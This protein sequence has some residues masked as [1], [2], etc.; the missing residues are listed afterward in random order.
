MTYMVPVGPP[1]LMEIRMTRLQASFGFVTAAV[2]VGALLVGKPT[3]ASAGD[4]AAA[5]KFSTFAS[6]DD[7]AAELKI[8]NA[9]LKKAVVSEAEY[10]DQVEGRFT[11]DA[12][13]IALIAIAL[14]LHD[15]DSALKPQAKAIAAAARKLAEAKDYAATKQAV[16]DLKAATDG[17]GKGAIELKWGKVSKLPGLMKDQV[18][19][20]NNKLKT[21]L[22][23][24]KK[25]TG[26]VAANAA[27]MALIAE[28]ATLYV[29]DT[30]KPT[31]GKK[32][33]KFSAD[34]RAAAV[35]L[36]AK[37]HNGD[38]AG[39]KAAMENLDQSCHACHDVF[40]PEKNAAINPAKNSEEK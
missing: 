1:Y 20:I 21:A 36:A 15:Q 25:R 37:A 16:E 19:A 9:D 5:P 7:L 27:T 13:T 11:R 24:F 22:R 4:D 31:E 26:E 2:L 38:E 32:W 6:A 39:A 3:S 28:N 33:T 8:L 18:P 14:G 10:K 17:E 35:D 34:M 30:K 12:D 29:A 23:R 40:N